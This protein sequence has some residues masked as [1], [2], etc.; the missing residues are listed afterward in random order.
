[1]QAPRNAALRSGDW[2]RLIANYRKRNLT[3]EAASKLEFDPQTTHVD[4]REN[5][6]M[7]MIPLS[8]AALDS[9]AVQKIELDTTN[10]SGTI[11]C[12]SS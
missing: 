1:M 2:K 12:F 3:D 7:Q 4:L 11:S 5:P 6:E 10:F 8:L 9:A